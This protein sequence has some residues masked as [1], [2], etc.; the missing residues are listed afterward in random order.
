MDVIVFDAEIQISEPKDNTVGKQ[1][2]DFNVALIDV[3]AGCV[4]PLVL[5]KLLLTVHPTCQKVAKT[6]VLKEQN[7]LT[8]PATP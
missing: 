1:H 5:T 6:V 7:V 8:H 3:H 4:R 2:A